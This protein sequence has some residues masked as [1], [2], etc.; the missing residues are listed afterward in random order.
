[1]NVILITA[2]PSGMATTYL[3]AR[4]LQSAAERLGWKVTVE[5]HGEARA[6]TPVDEATLEAA[7]LVVVAADRIPDAARFAG[8]RVFQGSIDLALPDPETFLRAPSVMPTSS[9]PR[10]RRTRRQ[11]V[12]PGGSA[13]SP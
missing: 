9:R 1:M 4:R 8:K 3:A 2:C 7:E 11:R 6:V 10:R 5:A 13:S 12:R